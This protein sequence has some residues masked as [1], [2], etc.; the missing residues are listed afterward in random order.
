VPL[1]IPEAAS[2]EI[3]DFAG[4]ASYPES[5]GH[6]APGK[7]PWIPDRKACIENLRFSCA[8]NVRNDKK[9]KV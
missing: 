5:R 4:E 3:F 8:P 7:W 6:E 9:L 2:P 1:V